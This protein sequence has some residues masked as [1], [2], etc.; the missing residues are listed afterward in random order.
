MSLWENTERGILQKGSVG[1]FGCEFYFTIVNFFYR[2]IIPVN[3]FG[4]F[5]GCI[6][7]FLDSEN[8]IIYG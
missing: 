2:D 3:P 4:A 1:S 7:R 6:F 8:N 5:D